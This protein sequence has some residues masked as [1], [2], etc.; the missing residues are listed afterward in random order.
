MSGAADTLWGGTTTGNEIISLTQ[1]NNYAQAGFGNATIYGGSGNDTLRS[2]NPSGHE[3]LCYGHVGR[4]RQ[5]IN[6]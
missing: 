3:R 1:G 4:R 2:G 6:C 5:C